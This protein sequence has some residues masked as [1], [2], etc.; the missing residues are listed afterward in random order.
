MRVVRVLIHIRTCADSRRARLMLSP[1]SSSPTQSN[2]MTP[3]AARAGEEKRRRRCKSASACYWLCANWGEANRATCPPSHTSPGCRRTS[4]AAASPP[5]PRHRLL[6]V[7]QIADGDK[8]RGRV[9]AQIVGSAGRIGEHARA[10]LIHDLDG[11]A[12]YAGEGEHAVAARN[13]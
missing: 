12:L 9:A 3:S 2:I 10:R 4:C 11:A 1:S 13:L 8:E 6:D 7:V 5:A